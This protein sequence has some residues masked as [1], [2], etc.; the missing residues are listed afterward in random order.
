M[1]QKI[2]GLCAVALA[3]WATQGVMAANVSADAKTEKGRVRLAERDI[4]TFVED[5]TLTVTE[6]TAVELLMV[7]GGGGGGANRTDANSG[8][9]GGAGGGAGG[10]IHKQALTLLPGTYSVAIGVGGGVSENGGDTMLS[11]SS[12]FV[13]TAFGGG[14]GADWDGKK[15]KSGG[16]GGG[17]TLSS[18]SGATRQEAGAASHGDEDNLGSAGGVACHQYGAGGGG[19]AGAAGET[20]TGSTPGKGGDGYAC[21]IS[22]TNVWYAGG[23]AGYRNKSQING[24]LGGGGSCVKAANGLSSTPGAGE[25]GLGGGGCGGAKGGNGI[26]IVSFVP[27]GGE[28]S[29]D[30]NLQG[31]DSTFPFLNDTVL[32]FTNGGTLTVTGAGHAEVLVVGGGGGGGALGQYGAG[33]GGAGGVIHRQG[34]FLNEGTYD[35]TTIP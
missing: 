10:V 31:G 14:A 5:G 2:R 7:G 29:A 12:D 28:D 8:Y 4:L 17:S 33:G 11:D 1:K 24:G 19:G 9:Q 15:G 18:A 35:I 25:D 20:P 6:E 23:G 34:V 13:L 21:A 22:G 16:S 30:F 27:E 32:V 26:M 3:F